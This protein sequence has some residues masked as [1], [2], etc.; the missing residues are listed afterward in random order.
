MAAV[1]FIDLRGEIHSDARGMSFFPWQGRLQA[2]ED[3]SNTF[4]LASIRPGCTRGNHL[5]PRHVEW[6]YPF[7][8]IGILIWEASPGQIEE[9]LIS[10]DS[11]LI[12]IAPGIAHAFKNPGPETLYLMAWRGAVGEVSATEPETVAYQVA[13]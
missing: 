5:H 10:G 12:Y 11:T 8:G 6:L 3:L 4:H 9:R 2:P 13:R 7:H 1:Q